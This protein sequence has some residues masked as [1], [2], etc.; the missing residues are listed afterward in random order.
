MAE[1][2]RNLQIHLQSHS[3]QSKSPS[4]RRVEVRARQS[5]RAFSSS[6]R[7]WNESLAVH[8]LPTDE[9]RQ[10]TARR[11]RILRG[12]TY[13]RPGHRTSPG[14]WL[15]GGGRLD[16]SFAAGDGTWIESVALVPE[17]SD[18]KSRERDWPMIPGTADSQSRVLSFPGRARTNPL[19]EPTQQDLC[20]REIVWIVRG[21]P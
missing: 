20:A 3:R 16:E 19:F 17:G 10:A 18:G 6:P 13:R 1:A 14:E 9:P 11:F 5:K 2:Q 21:S 7:L 12:A 8:Y 15:G 4:R